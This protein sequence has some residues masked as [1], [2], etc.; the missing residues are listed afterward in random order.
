MLLA[1]VLFAGVYAYLGTQRIER[2]RIE[3]EGEHLQAQALQSRLQAWR[4]QRFWTV[5][6][7]QVRKAAEADPWVARAQAWRLWP[8]TLVVHATAEVPVARWGE[9]GLVD[10]RGRVFY[11]PGGTGGFEHLLRL[12]G[13]DPAAAPELL[14]L[15]SQLARQASEWGLIRLMAVPGG[16]VLTHWSSQRPVWLEQ[17]QAATR[18]ARL[19]RAWPQVKPS[20]RRATAMIDLRYSNGFVIKLRKEH[21]G[22]E[23]TE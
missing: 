22:V 1:L 23:K 20:L 18:L 19:Q 21:D 6:L 3:V 9:K 11:P 14:A 15:A 17:A 2:I 10:R 4:G 12:D 7:Q 16:S 5:D 13:P 8:H